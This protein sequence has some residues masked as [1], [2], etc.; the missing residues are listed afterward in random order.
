MLTLRENV[1][2]LVASDKSNDAV[3]EILFTTPM[4]SPKFILY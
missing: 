1:G 3:A 4:H 2:C